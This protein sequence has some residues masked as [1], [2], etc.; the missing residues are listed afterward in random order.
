MLWQ[1]YQLIR[2]K[3]GRVLAMIFNNPNPPWFIIW[4]KSSFHSAKLNLIQGALDGGYFLLAPVTSVKS[5]IYLLVSSVSATWGLLFP[6]RF[7]SYLSSLLFS[8]S[9]SVVLYICYLIGIR[10]LLSIFRTIYFDVDLAPASQML[11]MLERPNA[12]KKRSPLLRHQSPSLHRS[13]APPP[14][15]IQQA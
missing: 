10:I 3:N 7:F 14:P 6:A 5:P 13:H 4:R 11:E 1:I 12:A 9:R 8:F 15:G 2:T